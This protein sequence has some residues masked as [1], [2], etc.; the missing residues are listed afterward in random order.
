MKEPSFSK[1]S[2]TECKSCHDPVGGKPKV[3]PFRVDGGHS[4][5]ETFCPRCFVYVRA[6]KEPERFATGAYQAVHCVLCGWDSVTTG[7]LRCGNCRGA[8]VLVL[9]PKEAA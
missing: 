1:R 4:D 9:P 3:A 7:V 2:M 8:N 6:P 5:Y